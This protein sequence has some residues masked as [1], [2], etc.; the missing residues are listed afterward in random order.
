M[1][2]I[3]IVRSLAGALALLSGFSSLPAPAQPVAAVPAVRVPCCRCVDGR[4]H[5]VNLNTRT[6]PWRVRRA[7]PSPTPFVTV[8]PA[9]HSAWT[10]AA[11]P[12]GWV[13][14][15]SGI[16]AGSYVYEL[17]IQ[18][19]RC[20]IGG[21]MTIDGVFSADNGG[22][23]ALIRP[24]NTVVGLGTRPLPNGFTA[25]TTFSPT[26]MAGP[27]TY[28]LRA[29]VRNLGS[30]SGFVLRGRILVRCPRDPAAGPFNPADQAIDQAVVDGA[31]TED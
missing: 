23:L 27:G 12:A 9:G 19:P 4:V 3:R 31:V 5:V 21:R 6:A 24:N 15:P 2:G 30:V 14:H 29:T 28:I 22:T 16:V 11:A 20:L 13:S 1:I 18:V 17:R 8:V 7:T 26:A 10:T 25:I